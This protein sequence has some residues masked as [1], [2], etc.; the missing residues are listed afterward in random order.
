M[1]TYHELAVMAQTTYDSITYLMMP[2][3]RETSSSVE[4]G[5]V[6]AYGKPHAV[7]ILP[8]TVRSAML[9]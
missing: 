4:R 5:H 6:Q 9:Y 2:S 7:L 3:P 8:G 1:T